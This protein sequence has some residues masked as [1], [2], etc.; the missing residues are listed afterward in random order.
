M[1]GGYFD[2]SNPTFFNDTLFSCIDRTN[3]TAE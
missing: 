1:F 2:A 3:D